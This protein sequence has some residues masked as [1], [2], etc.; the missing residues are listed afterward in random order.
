MLLPAYTSNNCLT[1]GR[2]DV[3]EALRSLRAS[4]QL[5]DTEHR[6]IEELVVLVERM[7]YRS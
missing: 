7:V 3:L 4:K 1:D 5:P 2:A 6:Q